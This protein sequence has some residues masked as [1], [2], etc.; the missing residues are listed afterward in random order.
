M[1][2]PATVEDLSKRSLRPLTDREKTVG[3]QWLDDAWSILLS[4]RPFVADKVTAD[5]QFGA[6]VV[7]VLCA[8]VIRVLNNPEG[9]YQ[10][11]I[12]D[13]QWS[14]DQA[15]STGQLYVSDAELALIGWPTDA[16]ASGAFTIRARSWSAQMPPDPWVPYGGAG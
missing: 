4:Q 11:S 10:E 3:Q 8:M 6:L 5:A 13:Y 1:S 9:K 12:D 2:N 14:R 15:V 16:G 7:Q